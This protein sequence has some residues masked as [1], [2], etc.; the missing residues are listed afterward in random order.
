MAR[1]KKSESP[2]EATLIEAAQT[3]SASAAE[4]AQQPA[5]EPAGVPS[6]AD[7]AADTAAQPLLDQIKQLEQELEKQRAFGKRNAEEKTLRKKILEARDD[8]TQIASEVEAL[9]TRRK[10]VEEHCDSLVSDLLDVINGQGN[11]FAAPAESA[12]KPAAPE[13]S[14]S[15]AKT[16]ADE[17]YEAQRHVKLADVWKIYGGKNSGKLLELLKDGKR[18]DNDCAADI[19][20]IGQLEEFCKT[21][22]LVDIKGI[23]EEKATMIDAIMDK[24]WGDHKPPEKAAAP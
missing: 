3:P 24:Y 14:A 11:L 13:S 4:P 12:G 20:T 16:T 23:G 8:M 1:R 17:W 19:E 10:V 6:A 21:R 2:P 18:K 15:P 22:H 9:K 5:T 7:T